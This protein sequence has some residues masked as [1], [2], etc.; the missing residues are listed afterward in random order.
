MTNF[1]VTVQIL[2]HILVL[3]Q[4]HISVIED[5][6]SNQTKA[7]M[8]DK[9][10][11]FTLFVNPIIGKLLKNSV[12]Y[13]QIPQ[14]YLPPYPPMHKAQFSTLFKRAKQKESI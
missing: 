12:S 1:N 10:L 11:N 14:S 6:I 3:K 2:A 7:V 13:R 8:G 9:Y 5:E 4:L